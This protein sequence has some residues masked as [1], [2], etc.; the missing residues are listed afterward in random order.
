MRS[1]LHILAV[2]AASFL[3]GGCERAADT[4]PPSLR[5]GEQEC[6]WCRMLVSEERFA[7]ALVY[8]TSHE[9]TKLVFDDV[10]C[11]FGYLS[12]Q[13]LSDPYKV[14]VHDLNTG[15]WLDA[16]TAVFVRSERLE[17]PMASRVAATSVR[18]D[19][20]KLLERFPGE[21]LTYDHLAKL[22]TPPSDSPAQ[23]GEHSP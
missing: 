4:S 5:L 12:E 1:P 14:Y 7:A 19:A 15:A 20:Q 11:V 22:F 9:V 16:R 2:A 13:P 18:A 6:A 21:I 23:P 17:T 10:N 8:K 3:L